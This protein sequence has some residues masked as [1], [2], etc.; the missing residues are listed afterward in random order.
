MVQPFTIAA[1]K[2]AM[3]QKSAILL[4]N[5]QT[6]GDYIQLSTVK[7]IM[8]EDPPFQPNFSMLVP[9]VIST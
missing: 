1:S 7:I 6:I 9:R 2:P 5:S 8:I 3:P 4:E